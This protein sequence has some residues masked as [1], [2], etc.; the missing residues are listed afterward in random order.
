MSDIEANKAVARSYMRAV[1]EGD[2]ETIEALQH[3]DCQWWILGHGDMSRA[4]FI[5][6]VK[7]GLLSAQKRTAEVIAIT[8]EGDRVAV[9]VRGEMVFPDRVY[10]NDYH[11][12]LIIRNGQ[13]VSGKE[14]MDTRAV[15]EAFSAGEGGQ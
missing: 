7:G 11:N 5:A 8:A 14:Y 1:E 15:A 9:E 2:V 3:P 10:R 12:L 6:S 13:I 4:D